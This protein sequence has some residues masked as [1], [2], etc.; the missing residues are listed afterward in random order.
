MAE[1]AGRSNFLGSV[2]TGLHPE[3]I[4]I[5]VVAYLFLPHR[6]GMSSGGHRGADFG[7]Y[8]SSPCVT[9]RANLLFVQSGG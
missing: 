3:A 8:T 6:N 1:I 5:V 2:L 4:A 9:T 7:C